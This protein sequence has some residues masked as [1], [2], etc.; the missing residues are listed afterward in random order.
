MAA[1]AHTENQTHKMDNTRNTQETPV[2]GKPAKR[3]FYYGLSREFTTAEN[4]K[5]LT[6]I[7]STSFLTQQKK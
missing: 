1:E 6:E 4:Q 3:G 7:S 2:W 5:F